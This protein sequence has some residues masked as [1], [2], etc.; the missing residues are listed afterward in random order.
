VTASTDYTYDALYRLTT[1]TG[2]EH[3]GQVSQPQP[4]W[5]D[6][7]RMNQ[8]LPTDGQAMRNYAENYAYDAVGNI[9]QVVHQAPNN[10]NWTR[11]YAYD[12]P[13]VPY[14]NN[15]LTSTKVGGLT[16]TYQCNANGD[17][18]QMPHF[19]SMGWDFKDQLHSADLVGGG[20][21]Y[22]IYDASGQRVRKVIERQGGLVEERI[23]LGAFEL[24]RETLNNTLTLERETL[25][26]MDDERRVAMVETKTVDLSAPQGSLPAAV[27]RYQLDN[28]L[29]SAVLELDENAA[30]ISYE[31]YYPYGSTSYQA[32]NSAIEVSLKHYRYTGKERDDESGLYYHG[33]RYY[34][35]WLGRWTACD[36]AAQTG[37]FSL[38]AYA[39]G[40][41]VRFIDPNGKQDVP[42]PHG[43]PAQLTP[44]Q[45]AQYHQRQQEQQERAEWHRPELRFAREHPTLTRIIEAVQ[46]IGGILLLAQDLQSAT[47]GVSSATLS[48]PTEAEVEQD[49]AEV[50]ALSG[51]SGAPS[52]SAAAS[53][54]QPTA[55]AAASP[56]PASPSSPAPTGEGTVD[57]SL[58]LQLTPVS[59]TPPATPVTPSSGAAPQ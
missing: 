12:E 2:R 14:T 56:P 9:L 55:P 24:Y 57:T 13:N 44:D 19:A 22:Y 18:T 35:P 28:H 59:T 43:K 36:P 17:M 53:G 48:Q 40:N 33:A 58:Q 39:A 8:P 4:D 29:G 31:E 6:G 15:R 46:T 10:G 26:V 11:T 51:Q 37:G 20:T 45:L 16:R 47:S 21:A 50:A 52:S 49:Q 34:A 27:T 23:Y 54:S 25:H 30:I 3:I 5:D 32:V 1:S 42:D 7:P 38:F 41:P